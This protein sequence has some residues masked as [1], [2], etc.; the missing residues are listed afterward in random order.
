MLQTALLA[1]I[2]FVLVLIEAPS[3]LESDPK[4]AKP[5]VIVAFALTVI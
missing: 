1:L 2:V 4:D 5:F 3:K